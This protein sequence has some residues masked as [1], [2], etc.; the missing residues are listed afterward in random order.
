MSG[1]VVE[2]ME[3]PLLKV[4]ERSK[5]APQVRRSGEGVERRE[6]NSGVSLRSKD[7]STVSLNVGRRMTLK[8]SHLLKAGNLAVKSQGIFTLN[9]RFGSERGNLSGSKAAT[10]KHSGFRAS[11]TRPPAL[12]VASLCNPR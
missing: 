4:H 11:P 3:L 2:E 12:K 10:F 5:L 6:D 1:D 7:S 9:Y 8:L